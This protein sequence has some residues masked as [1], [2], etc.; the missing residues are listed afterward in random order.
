M[1]L[2]KEVKNYVEEHIQT[3]HDRRIESMKKTDLKGLLKKKNPYLFKA[4]HMETAQEL[5]ESLLAAKLSSAEEEIIGDF[6]E[7]MAVFVVR[8]THNGHKSGIKGFDF[9]YEDDNTHY[10]FAMKSGQNWGNAAQWNA[11]VADCVG[12]L[13]TFN[14]SQHKGSSKCYLGISYGKCKATLRHGIITQVCGQEFWYMISGVKD[15]YKKIVQP[16][17]YEARNRNQIFN[18]DKASLINRLTGEL[19]NEFCDEK[20]NILWDKLVQFNSG[21]LKD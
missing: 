18:N 13:K 5:I 17:G 21:N 9:E 16:I 7:G 4:K 1:P 12:A 15:F 14:S 6:M 8:K 19:I 10:L 20:G 3:F 2:A 11:L